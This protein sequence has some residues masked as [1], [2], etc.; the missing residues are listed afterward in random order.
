MVK[1]IATSTLIVNNKGKSLVP[2]RNPRGV[3]RIEDVLLP[4]NDRFRFYS[5]KDLYESRE[6]SFKVLMMKWFYRQSV[7]SYFFKLWSKYFRMR[8]LDLNQWYDLVKFKPMK[9]QVKL[10]LDLYEHFPQ[11]LNSKQVIMINKLKKQLDI[12]NLL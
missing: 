4:G 6:K 2:S 3:L 8:R 9:Y 10:L 12:P 7:Y 11:Y 5:F 1:T